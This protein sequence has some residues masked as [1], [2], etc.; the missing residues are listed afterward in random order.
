ML[1]LEKKV[2]RTD[3][4]IQTQTRARTHQYVHT[5]NHSKFSPLYYRTFGFCDAGI[6]V[7]QFVNVFLW[8]PSRIESGTS[9]F[10]LVCL[11]LYVCV[12]VCVTTGYII[13][14][15]RKLNTSHRKGKK[16]YKCFSK[17]HKIKKARFAKEKNQTT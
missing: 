6:V 14:A 15:Y 12:R 17:T 13:S 2:Y 10:N 16:E 1:A 9:V 3:T 11:L 8:F 7:R 5:Y 4:H